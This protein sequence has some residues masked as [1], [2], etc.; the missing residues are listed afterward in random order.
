MTNYF[1]S[2]ACLAVFAGVAHG[3]DKPAPA[4]SPAATPAAS[5]AARFVQA[6][7]GNTLGFA[8]MQAGAEN[9]GTFKQFTVELVYDDKNPAAGKLTVTVQIP[10]LDTQDQERDDTLKGA[11]LLAAAKFPT[12][13]FVSSTLAKKADGSLSAT[14][15][16]TLRGVTREV[17]LPLSLKPAGKGHELTGS[18]TLKRLDFGVGQGE[19]QST[20]WVGNDV[21]LT[22]K[23]QLVPAGR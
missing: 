15:K 1:R 19:W 8:F 10:S 17:T 14:G 23:V 11:D 6:A 4:P 18:V 9:S 2:L 3:A 12:A 20:E 21:K 13:N 22:Y 5:T 16:L 7:N